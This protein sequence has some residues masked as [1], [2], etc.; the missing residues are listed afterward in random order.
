MTVGPI[1]WSLNSK[2]VTTPKFPPPP[3]IA[4]NRSLFSC[5]L[6]VR[7]WPSAVTISTDITLSMLRPHFPLNQ[8]RPPDSVS[9]PTPVADTTPPVV[10]SPCACAA[11]SKSH[12]VAP[13]ATHARRV[14][15][16]TVTDLIRDRSISIPP[17]HDPLPEP[18]WPP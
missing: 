10:A 11:R 13:P 12:Q 4:Q 5:S 9:P 6:A 16:S 8:P 14:E 17:S 15:G 3:R 7:T 1:G 2:V 18:L